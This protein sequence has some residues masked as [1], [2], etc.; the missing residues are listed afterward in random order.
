MNMYEVWTNRAIFDDYPYSSYIGELSLYVFAATPGQ[1]KME[2]IKAG[3]AA[4]ESFTDLRAKLIFKGVDRE[5]GIVWQG[6]DPDPY[7]PDYDQNMCYIHGT[8]NWPLHHV[9]A[10]KEELGHISTDILFGWDAEATILASFD[11]W[12]EACDW[13]RQYEAEQAVQS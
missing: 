6:E 8:T 9:I 7:H 13:A 1:A 5:A 12:E 11:S 3:Y 2:W 4:V 10:V